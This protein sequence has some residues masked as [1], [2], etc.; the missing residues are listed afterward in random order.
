MLP[1]SEGSAMREVVCQYEEPT[2]ASFTSSNVNES[3]MWPAGPQ[4]DRS[5]LHEP[6]VSNEQAIALLT[7]LVE[8]PISA[9]STQLPIVETVAHASSDSSFLL[10]SERTDRNE[11]SNH[12]GNDRRSTLNRTDD[13]RIYSRSRIADTSTSTAS[14]LVHVAAASTSS[15][16]LATKAK[17]SQR[18]SCSYPGCNKTLIR[19]T[20][21]SRHMRTHTGEKPFSCMWPNCGKKFSCNHNCIRHF[22][23]HSAI[24]P[25][26]CTRCM[27]TFKKQL[28]H[29]NHMKMCRSS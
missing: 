10:K 11:H 23:Q 6:S 4:V 29:D 5:S 17:K 16:T 8:V 27:R 21:L 28:T 13:S 20:D 15:R 7:P 12:G 26:K 1:V 18:A 9:E 22:R 19:L 2:Q 3:S 24:E 25:Y 14:R